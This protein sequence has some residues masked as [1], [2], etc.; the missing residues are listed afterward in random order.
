MNQPLVSVLIANYNHEDTIVETLKSVLNQT[1]KNMQ[2]I[3]VDDGSTDQSWQL[4]NQ[5]DDPRIEAYRLEKN[6]HICAATNYGIAKIKG[7]YVARLDSDDLWYPEK[8]ERQLTY[9]AEN[10]DCKVCFTWCDFIDEN[11]VNINHIETDRVRL[12]EVA[13]VDQ[14][15]AVERFYFRGNCL[16]HSSVLMEGKV[17]R[18]IG[19]YD[20]G[21]N[22]LHDLDYWM[23]IAKKYRI[24]VI[25]EK[26]M[27]VRRFIKQENLMTN[28]SNMSEGAEIRVFNEYMELRAHYFE[29]LSDDLL[30]KAFGKYFR[31][32]GVLDSK[33]LECEKAFLMCRPQDGWTGIPPAGL[34]R[35]HELMIDEEMKQILE[36]D[37][38][39][40]IRDYYKLL[41][42]HLYDDSILQMKKRQLQDEIKLL[43]FEKE[44]LRNEIQMYAGSTSWKI[45][46][47]LRALG[48]IRKRS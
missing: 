7:N 27:A 40:G 4:I 45:T 16:S 29:G 18:D 17:M 46:K 35:L 36:N 41:E 32:P 19:E 3:V 6:Q 9:M 15:D 43:E 10:K 39:F 33:Q 48:N 23:R 44:N 22:Q 2:I 37:Y 20:A 1:Y 24:D 25:Q 13:F 34:R 12:H 8:I 28:M 47:P 21:Y 11:G 5:F 31:K 30:V 38:N 14:A 26:Y 42:N